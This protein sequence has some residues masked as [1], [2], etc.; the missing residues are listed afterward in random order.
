MNCGPSFDLRPVAFSAV[1]QLRVDALNGIEIKAQGRV[2]FKQDD[3]GNGVDLDGLD[4]L[5]LNFR[6]MR[7]VGCAGLWSAFRLVLSQGRLHNR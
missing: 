1:P 5:A 6:E 3:N 4:D 2:V 7:Q